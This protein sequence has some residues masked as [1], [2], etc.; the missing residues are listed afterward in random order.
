MRGKWCIFPD[1][2]AP[3]PGRRFR[4]PLVV[5]RDSRGEATLR[6]RRWGTVKGSERK[7]SEC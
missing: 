7:S 4:D 6:K 3:E 5:P 2:R 1:L